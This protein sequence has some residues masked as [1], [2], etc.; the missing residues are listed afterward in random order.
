MQW[1]IW[2]NGTHGVPIDD[3]SKQ[4]N[5]Y[6]ET[7]NRLETCKPENYIPLL[8]TCDFLL[9]EYILLLYFAAY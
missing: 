5:R 9:L 4:Y 1:A 8:V 3:T 7:N 6:T 2:A